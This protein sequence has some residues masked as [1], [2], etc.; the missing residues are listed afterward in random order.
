MMI[1]RGIS[2]DTK[3]NLKLPLNAFSIWEAL[4]KRLLTSSGTERYTALDKLLN[5]KKPANRSLAETLDDVERFAKEAYEKTELRFL[6]DL[7]WYL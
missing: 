5:W 7:V 2:N 3:M 6:S 4:K 1:E